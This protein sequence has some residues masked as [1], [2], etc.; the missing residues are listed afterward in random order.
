[1]GVTLRI[2]PIVELTCRPALQRDLLRET[3]YNNE[4]DF[5]SGA[6]EPSP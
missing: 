6:G 1:V 5:K 4:T 3:P 2:T